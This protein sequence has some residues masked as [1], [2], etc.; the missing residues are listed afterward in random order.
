MKGI[1][2]NTSIHTTERL[3]FRDKIEVQDQEI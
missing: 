1:T 2:S 3:N